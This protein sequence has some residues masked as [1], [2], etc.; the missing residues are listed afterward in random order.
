MRNGLW[1]Q[2]DF[3]QLWGAV[4]VS[5]YGSL[6]RAT[7]LTFTAILVLGASPAD[8]G[9]LRLAEMV[10][11][12]LVGL[13]AGAWVDRVRRRPV[14][15]VTDLARALAL[16]SI[17]VAALLGVLGF[18]H[19]LLVA[20][21]VSTLGV[22][23]D[24]A[25][26]SYLPSIVRH[27]DLVEANSTLTAGVSVVEAVA[28]SS[29]GW[30]VQILTAP[31][32]LFV[33]ALS[34]LGS[35]LFV[36]RIRTPEPSRTQ[37]EAPHAERLLA[38][39]AREV[40]EGLNTVWR[41]PILRGLALAAA[42]QHIAYGIIGTLI[43]LYLN[44]VVGFE[45]GVLG[46][47]F[48]VG[49]VSAFAGAV[50]AGRFHR[51]G[52]G[53]IMVACLLLAAVGEALVPLVSSVSLAAVA[54]LVGQQIITDSVLTIYDITQVSLRQGITPNHLLGRVNAS[55]RVT[56]SGGLFLGTLLAGGLSESI[57]MRATLWVAVAL[58][59]LAA[60]AL[61]VSPVRQIRRV[62]EAPVMATP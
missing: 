47:I 32:A 62:P 54:L 38:L 12:F 27:D 61:A 35:A 16:V 60:F 23:F 1:R 13:V 58:T 48:A 34:F 9:A 45:P 24:V 40:T 57:G 22:F 2:S 41:Q 50:I 20:A 17:P 5:T 29:G 33:D 30:L 15:I 7:A 19:L 51:A 37:A 31:I 43:L 49:G 42:A 4:V 44:Q 10:P 26:Q 55:V 18:G 6:V 25:Y 3:R 56:E 21:L 53:A 28:F 46:M 36:G 8:I 14:M 11:G 59:M 52:V 39:F